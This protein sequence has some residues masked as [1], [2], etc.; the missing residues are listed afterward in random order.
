MHKAKKLE[1]QWFYRGSTIDHLVGNPVYKLRLVNGNLKLES[2]NRSHLKPNPSPRGTPSFGTVTPRA[3]PVVIEL[4]YV[5]V[6]GTG[7]NEHCE[8]G[9]FSGAAGGASSWVNPERGTVGGLAAGHHGLGSTTYVSLGS[10]TWVYLLLFSSTS[11][12][13]FSWA[14]V[15]VYLL[16]FSSTSFHDFSWV[17]VRVY[18]LLLILFLSAFFLANVFVQLS[19]DGS[20]E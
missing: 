20:P 19:K 6:V 10:G 11:F 7:T 14:R 17:R 2:V 5:D 4:G 12:H 13:D 1:D 3:S 8:K 15:R 18:L 16:F 9:Y